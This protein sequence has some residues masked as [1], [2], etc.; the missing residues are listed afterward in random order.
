MEYCGTAENSKMD[1]V[2]AIPDKVHTCE[3]RSYFMLIGQGEIPFLEQRMEE[4]INRKY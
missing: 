4:L 2:D 1:Y 3:M